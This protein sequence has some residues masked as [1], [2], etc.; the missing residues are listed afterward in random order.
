MSGILPLLLANSY[1][2]LQTLTES[3]YYQFKA[4]MSDLNIDDEDFQP[5]MSQLRTKNLRGLVNQYAQKGLTNK[6]KFLVTIW[7]CFFGREH[8]KDREICWSLE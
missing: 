3:Y 8:E 1:C 2:F 5:V 6:K 4:R 7:H